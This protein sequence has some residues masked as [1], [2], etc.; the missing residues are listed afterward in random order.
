MFGRT[1]ACLKTVGN[2]SKSFVK[3]TINRI[4]ST[5]GLRLGIA[6]M[7]GLTAATMMI[8]TSTTCDADV[9]AKA[10]LHPL[11]KE[12]DS[13]YIKVDSVHTIYYHVYGNPHGKPV[14]FVHG[15]PGGGTAPEVE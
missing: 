4:N 3:P 9:N 13:G 12:I 11:S 15:G 5:N 8:S 1:R 14:L 10:V 2:I 7:I 6:G